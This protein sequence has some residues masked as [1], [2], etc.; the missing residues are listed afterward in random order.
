MTDYRIKVSVR[1]ARL[2]R[3]IEAAGH[4][5]VAAFCKAEGLNY[6]QVNALIGLREAPIGKNGRFTQTA[7][8]LM[9][10]LCALPQELWTERQLTM[11]LPRSTYETDVDEIDIDN[12]I[13][14]MRQADHLLE[15]LTPREK[16][17][18]EHLA[19]DGLVKEVAKQHNVSSTRLQKIRDRAYRRGRSVTA[20]EKRETEK[21]RFWYAV[22][23]GYTPPKDIWP[24]SNHL[25]E[26][27]GEE[28]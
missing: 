10:A 5:S 16:E 27:D 9:E 6:G 26:D 25:H 4:S 2:L 12:R 28:Q 19:E 11:N 21:A 18:V 7:S 3:A 24:K 22:E 8:M 13:S 23:H 15:R 17:I 1:N 20:H 14:D